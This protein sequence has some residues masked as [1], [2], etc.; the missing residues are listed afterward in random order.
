MSIN[1]SIVDQRITRVM[2]E[3]RRMAEEEL[4]VKADDTRLKSVAFVFLVVQLTLDLED[5]NAFDCLTEGGGD[6]GV[7][8]L[9]LSEERDGEFTITLFQG[10]YKN[11]LKGDANFPEVSIK[12]LIDAARYIA[13]PKASLNNINARLETRI[14]EARSLIRDGALP[15]I[16]IVACNNGL[17]WSSAAE[18]AIQ[19]ANLGSQVAWEHVNHDRIVTLLQSQR[20]INDTLSLTGKALV[21]ERNFMRVMVGRMAADDIALLF[22]KYGE[23]L[24][25]RNIRRYLGLQKNRVNEDIHRTLL[26]LQERERFYMY[27]NGVTMTCRKFAHNAL[28]GQDFK[29]NVEDLQIINGGQT[30][31]TIFKTWAGAQKQSLMPA[32]V[33]VRLYELPT[34]QSGFEL[35]TEQSDLVQ[36]ITYATNSQNPVDLRDLR[37][38][39]QKQKRLALD[40]QQLGWSYRRMRSVKGVDAKEITSG[41]AAVAVLSIWRKRPHQAKSHSRDH[42]GKLYDLIFD[43]ALTGAEVIVGVQLYRIA[44]TH[45]RRQS[46][47]AQPLHI[48]YSSCFVAMRMG[49]RLLHALHTSQLTHKVFAEAQE[50]VHLHGEDDFQASVRDVSTA[51]RQLY[52]DVEKLSLQ[53][54]A[55]TFRR[56]DLLQILDNMPIEDV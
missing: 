52:G 47:T 39:D 53:Q 22:E 50:H 27:N 45:R 11:N 10:K 28:Q 13:D 35:P 18:E 15:R 12:G 26:E 7:D 51:L 29:V 55:A 42:F 8:A 56:G 44:E 5:K 24:L 30:C 16:R 14:E 31:M 1:V 23:A 2:D 25:E 33:L 49:Q 40:I 54:L 4:G 38:K 48:R 9:H 41:S 6:F 20:T 3:I 17:R 19:R 46:A 32:D 37:S 21:E 36:R 34:E 43:D